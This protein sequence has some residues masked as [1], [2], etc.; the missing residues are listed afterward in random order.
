MPE[1]GG[2]AMNQSLAAA[3]PAICGL[4]QKELERQQGHL[5][6]IASEN[7]A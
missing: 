7:F 2:A 1:F 4:I 3:D 6:L 5:E